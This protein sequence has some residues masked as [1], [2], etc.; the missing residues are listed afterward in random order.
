[1]ALQ[2]ATT[3]DIVDIRPLGHRLRD[4][5]STAIVRDD[6]IEVMRLVFVDGR[7]MPEN[8]VDGPVTFQCLEGSV[9]L[10]VAGEQRVLQQ[11]DLVYL[12][13]GVPYALSGDGDA[14]VLMTVVRG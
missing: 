6:R 12:S 13:G 8:H 2:H 14:S 4:S 7:G 3:G 5:V 11:G 1:M 9:V 10:E